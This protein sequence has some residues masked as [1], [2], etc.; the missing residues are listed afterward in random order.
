MCDNPITSTEKG[1]IDVNT[2]RRQDFIDNVHKSIAKRNDDWSIQVHNRIEAKDL[3]N[4]TYHRN[5]SINFQN[6]KNIPLCH[7]G[8]A[9]KAGRPQNAS[10]NEAFI[11]L[12]EHMESNVGLIFSIKELTVRMQRECDETDQIENRYLK[13]KLLKYFGENIMVISN[14]GKPDLLV[15]R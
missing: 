4:A 11:K 14:E 2:V 12:V 10:R 3:L 5:C 15:L 8:V 13:Q 9:K 1:T 7:G 6:L